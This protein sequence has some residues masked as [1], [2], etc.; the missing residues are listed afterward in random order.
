MK[1]VAAL[2]VL[3]FSI[4]VFATTMKDKECGMLDS[5]PSI[6][7]T[8]EFAII[9]KN[10]QYFPKTIVLRKGVPTRL[11]FTSVDRAHDIKIEGMRIRENVVPGKIAIVDFTPQEA[12]TFEYVCDVYCGPGHRGMK[13]MIIVL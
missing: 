1:L 11:Y 9:A 8:Q 10:Y 2:M 6:E 3:T 7:A 4:P 12:R 5:M 13:G